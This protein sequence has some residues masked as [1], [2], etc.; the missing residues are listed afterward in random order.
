M[1]E[2]TWKGIALVVSVLLLSA[3]GY[4]WDRMSQY[5]PQAEQLTS[6]AVVDE[7]LNKNWE[8]EV[9]KHNWK[10]TVRIKTGLFI[11]SIKFA[12]A[13]EVNVAGYVWQ[14]YKDGVHDKYKPAQG[15]AGFVFPEQIN[16]GSDLG[17]R[18]EYRMRQGDEEIIGWYFEA[19]LR[20]DF[21]Y[22]KY[23]FDNKTVWVRI[24]PKVFADNVVLTPD[25]GSYKGGTGTDDRFGL[26][27]SIVLGTWTHKD[28]F[29]D[30]HLANYDTDFG[31]QDY[32]GMEAFPELRFNVVIC[33]NFR[34]AFIVNLLPLL[35]VLSLLY[36]TLLLVT[37]DPELSTRF[38]FSASGVM[39]S[40]SA[41]FFVVLLAH[42]QVRDQF[43]GWSAVY[44]E[45]FYF[46]V[47]VFLVLGAAYAYLF[48]DKH[49]GFLG[50][51]Y[52]RDN[53]ALKVGFWPFV[54][55]W[56]LVISVTF[57]EL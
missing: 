29:F 51:L 24:W 13:S 52:K 38:G 44:I 9:K 19:T 8:P 35:M 56:M 25:L 16:S 18:E 42:M 47:Y 41:L 17:A 12:N 36:G 10:P 46:L 15:E 3:L 45:Y 4:T 20:Q 2:R 14:H 26:D 40:C 55:F 39:G 28:T 21:D 53:L 11:Q 48:A 23:P 32:I 50:F 37:E 33:R 6:D 57:L 22:T 31:I 5:K 43:A 1:K 7:F 49:A 54:F 34:D 30:Y 27:E